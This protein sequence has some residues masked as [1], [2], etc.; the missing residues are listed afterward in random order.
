[1]NLQ[2]LIRI[3]FV[4]GAFLIIIIIIINQLSSSMI[5]ILHIPSPF[6]CPFRNGWYGCLLM[7]CVCENMA[8][9]CQN[10]SIVV[11]TIST[12]TDKKENGKNFKIH[13]TVQYIYRGQTRTKRKWKCASLMLMQVRG[14][15]SVR[16]RVRTCDIFVY[17]YIEYVRRSDVWLCVWMDSPRGGS[18]RGNVAAIPAVWGGSCRWSWTIDWLMALELWGLGMDGL[19]DFRTSVHGK[20]STKYCC[21]Y[22]R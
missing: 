9:E 11:D 22:G 17:G 7:T 5:L 12:S 8:P 13:D 2:I 15:A 14:V 18:G 20:Y 16:H 4:C 1:M 19:Y 21:R 3:A 10:P 6:P